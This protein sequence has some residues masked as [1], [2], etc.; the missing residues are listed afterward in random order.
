MNS[1]ADFVLDDALAQYGENAARLLH[2]G[3]NISGGA[4]CRTLSRTVRSVEERRH[5]LLTRYDEK[6]MPPAAEWLA[7]NCYLLRRQ[8]DAAIENLANAGKLQRSG[9][10]AA[11]VSL[12]RT[13]LRCSGGFL[14]KTR[15]GLFFSGCGRAYILNRRE[16]DAL[17]PAL[18]TA[19]I[20]EIAELYLKNNLTDEAAGTA[21]NLFTALRELSTE[22]YAETVL[23]IDSVD[24]I[25]MCDPSGEYPLMSEKTRF[26]YRK[27]VSKI[28]QKRGVSEVRAANKAILRAREQSAKKRHVGFQLYS[29]P[30]GSSFAARSALYICI[31]ALFCFAA[32]AVTAF[33]A[34]SI[35][36]FFLTLLPYY[37][38]TKLLL[39][40]LITVF[41]PARHLPR[42][43][44]EDGVPAEG[45]TLCVICALLT[46]PDSGKKL[47]SRLEQYHLANREC[48]DN[49]IFGILADLPDAKLEVMPSDAQI[50]ENS[51]AAIEALN[52]KYGGGFFLFTRPRRFLKSDKKF[53]VFERKRGAV[54]AL[55]RLLCGEKPQI[56]VTAG[57]ALALRGVKYLLTLDEDTRLVPGSARQLIGAMLHPLNK[58]VFD[59]SRG[60]IIAGHG[61]IQP[62]M[63]TE[64]RSV[65]ASA[66]ARIFAGQGGVDPYGGDV[67][68]VYF[69]AFASGGFAG[70]GI[71]DCESFV[72][73]L[74]AKIP[75]NRVLSHDALEGAYLR[76]GFMGDVEL[77][78]T[79]PKDMLAY[80][81]RMHRWV[82]GDWQNLPWL[83]SRG[84]GFAPIDRFRL[85]D[86]VR[87]SL[88]PVATFLSISVFVCFAVLQRRI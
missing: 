72:R 22:S 2:V 77:C 27:R 69:D 31:L 55:C 13:L 21:K 39:D 10:T 30:V 23:E 85:F 46:S 17:V 44:L 57:G 51:R 45:R 53:S 24:R 61:I 41:S 26:H 37:E 28:A 75:E 6:P 18:N 15:F 11:I 1:S 48:G 68:E 14:S 73:C 87:R 54:A 62:R 81:R 64:L 5:D 66:F 33:L 38:L 84:R 32:A 83:F 52:E 8:A 58:A 47:A 88:M 20:F 16:L 9:D 34:D 70:K 12:C 35:A 19:I 63:T 65:N 3:G 50:I 59:E 82:R 78:D 76:G 36:V 71:I 7:D 49:L 86:S 80:F 25:L 67:S 42:M 40:R 29:Q 4:L 43:E 56:T 60:R 74:D 79:Y